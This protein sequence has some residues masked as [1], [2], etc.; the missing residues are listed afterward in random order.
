M[1]KLCKYTRPSQKRLYDLSYHLN[2]SDNL[3]L[4][5]KIS[6]LVK[7]I[8]ERYS[9]EV[10][11]TKRRIWFIKADKKLIQLMV[12]K[13]RIFIKIKASEGWLE[14]K[15]H[16]WEDFSRIFCMIN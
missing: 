16:D 11:F 3:R 9:C 4:R 5:A 10:V 12:E 1:S 7:I 6:K 8:P 2:N 14:T 13:Q 15:L